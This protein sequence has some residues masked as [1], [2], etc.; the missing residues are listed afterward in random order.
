MICRVDGKGRILIPKEVREK[1]GIRSLV[2]LRV[3]KDRLILIPVND[4]LEEL[5][6]NVV[7]GTSDVAREIRGLRRVAEREALR[8][9]ESRWS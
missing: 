9:V 7:K 3:E 4:P 6:A 1:L 2:K 8:E 5:T